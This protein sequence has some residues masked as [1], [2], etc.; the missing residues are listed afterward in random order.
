MQVIEWWLSQQFPFLRARPDGLLPTHSGSGS[1]RRVPSFF[2]NEQRL[3]DRSEQ[4]GCRSIGHRLDS[5]NVVVIEDFCRYSP[6][7]QARL[8]DLAHVKF[9]LTAVNR[10]AESLN[11]KKH[12]KKNYLYEKIEFL[13]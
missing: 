9:P 13:I 3:G 8:D 2:K 10:Y 6:A 4:P 12:N 1:R 5:S 7:R 11:C